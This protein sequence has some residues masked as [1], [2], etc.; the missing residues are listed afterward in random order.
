MKLSLL[1]LVASS[2][3]VVLWLTVSEKYSP[4]QATRLVPGVA[5]SVSKVVLQESMAPLDLTI[6]HDM[7]EQ[8]IVEAGDVITE[9][10]AQ[11]PLQV[12]KEDDIQFN[13]RLLLETRENAL[14]P[15]IDGAV[16]E[17]EVKT[18]SP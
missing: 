8:F 6:T 16:V 7:L 1:L 15:L 17:I 4:E 9:N 12:K 10:Q 13:G 18:K 14:M 5:E 11:L 3:A 2:M